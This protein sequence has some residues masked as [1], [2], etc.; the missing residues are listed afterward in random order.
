[1]CIHDLYLCYFLSR[2][3]GLRSTNHYIKTLTY[4]YNDFNESRMTYF[5]EHGYIGIANSMIYV[6]LGEER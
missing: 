2:F 6:Y 3:H 1:M 4:G 5:I